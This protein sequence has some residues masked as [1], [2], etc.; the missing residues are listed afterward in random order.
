M[1]EI[2]RARYYPYMPPALPGEGDDAYTDRLTGADK[3]NRVPYD[4]RRRRECSIGYHG[5]CSDPKGE[6]CKC[7]CH[8]FK[9]VQFVEE[10]TKS[11]KTRRWGVLAKDN[12]TKLGEV[13]WFSQWRQYAFF[14]EPRIVLAGSCFIDLAAFIKAVMDARRKS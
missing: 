10:N 8:S 7:P 14:P 4:H 2:I 11:L 5:N 9:W 1:T 6:D 3:T 13:R 12:G